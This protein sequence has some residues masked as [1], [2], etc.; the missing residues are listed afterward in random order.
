MVT[1]YSC[2][3]SST[4]MKKKLQVDKLTESLSLSIS[5]LY[6]PHKTHKSVLSISH[7]EKLIIS[8]TMMPKKVLCFLFPDDSWCRGAQGSRC[9]SKAM[10]SYDFAAEG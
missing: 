1:S 9:G 8:H 2:S 5:Q 4:M 3:C 10:A 6:K 7:S